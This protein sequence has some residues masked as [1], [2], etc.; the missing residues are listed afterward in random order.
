MGHSFVDRILLSQIFC[1]KDRKEH[2]QV[3]SDMEI[4]LTAVA[5][6]PTFTLDKPASVACQ[7]LM[8]KIG[9]KLFQSKQY[10]QAADWFLLCTH[11]SFKSVSSSGDAKCYRKAALCHIHS[12][13]Y[14][15][16]SAVISRCPGNEASTH[17]LTFLAATYQG[18]EDDAVTAIDGMIKAPDFD[19][20]MLLL[21]TQLAHESHMKN[22]LLSVLGGLLE[23]LK[24]SGSLESELEGMTL[25]RCMIRIA[26]E[27]TREPDAN[28]ATVLPTLV[29]YL[30]MARDLVLEAEAKKSANLIV[31]DISWLWRTAYN[32]AIRGCSGWDELVVAELFSCARQVQLCS[33]ILNEITSFRE[34][35]SQH[36]Q[37]NQEQDILQQL[38]KL[39]GLSF[40]FEVE[41]LCILEDWERIGKVIQDATESKT[42]ISLE[43]F[44]AIA[45]LLWVRPLCPTH[46]L[47]AALEAILKACLE[48]GSMDCD[49]FSRWLRA[50]VSILLSRNRHSDREKALGYVEQAS[51]VIKENQEAEY[52][53]DER[54]WLLTTSYNCGIESLQITDLD[55]A[56]RWFE[57]A[58]LIARYSQ[59]GES[60]AQQIE[61]SYRHL[62]ARYGQRSKNAT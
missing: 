11:A 6:D 39:T 36:R 27:M 19:R 34:I 30:Q 51:D 57:A 38:D 14:A 56:K 61:D 32:L 23:T 16:A 42:T 2:K 4:A 41:Q 26:T 24:G 8:F 13:A 12:K 9:A 48:R 17:Y 15:Q 45:D 1:L 58:T 43:T 7:S 52:P 3:V 59:G 46:V 49:R 20:K 44:E 18:R 21:A 33:S 47:Y 53:Q 55:H 29:S 62:L 10:P 60:R 54:T 25:I 28:L 22:L 35:T 50:I 37:A 40:V 31:K 5:K